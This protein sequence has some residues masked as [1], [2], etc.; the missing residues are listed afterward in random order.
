MGSQRKGGL[1]VARLSL[2]DLTCVDCTLLDVRNFLFRQ[3]RR[4]HDGFDRHAKRQ[5][6]GGYPFL[7]FFL[8]FGGGRQSSL[9]PPSRGR[10]GRATDTC[11]FRAPP[12]H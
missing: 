1:Q 2:E 4:L 6:V 11:A 12:R 10:G 3:S 5:K 7:R 8:A 9:I